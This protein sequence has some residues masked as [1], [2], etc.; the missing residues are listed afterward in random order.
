[1]K[2][3][4]SFAQAREGWRDHQAIL[5]VASQNRS[6]RVADPIRRDAANV[7]FQRAGLNLAWQQQGNAQR[8]KDAS[9][10]MEDLDLRSFC[11]WLITSAIRSEERGL[12][13]S[14]DTEA[15]THCYKKCSGSVVVI[16]SWNVRFR[17]ADS[18]RLF[19][20]VQSSHA[21]RRPESPQ[22]D[23]NL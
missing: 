17:R 14:T 6:D 7:N 21:H 23:C 9:R 3:M 10:S 16:S 15:E 19:K 11:C 20:N 13:R 22:G 5:A 18:K 8:Q 4:L 2:T 1:M 12:H